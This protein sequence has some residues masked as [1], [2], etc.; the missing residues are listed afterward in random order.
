MNEQIN[1]SPLSDDPET[2]YLG[3]YMCVDDAKLRL[4]SI[5]DDLRYDRSDVDIVSLAM[6]NHSNLRLGSLGFRQI[7]GN[8]LQHE[9]SGI[10]CLI[11]KFRALGAS[12][13]DTTRYTPRGEHDYYILTP[14]QTACQYV[15]GYPLEQAVE[16]VTGLITRQPINLY[17]LLDYLE[18]KSKHQ[19]FAKAIGHLRLVQR[20]AV[21]S[22]PLKSRRAL[23]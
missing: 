23:G 7:S 8:V 10:K 3:P 13:F 6:R 22:E 19:E 17:K 2:L 5:F 20:E 12:P 14:T 21:I 9:A 1:Q 15:D 11:P 16:R 18:R 4:I